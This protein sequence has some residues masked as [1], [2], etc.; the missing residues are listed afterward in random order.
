MRISKPSRN[1]KERRSV[2]SRAPGNQQKNSNPRLT[3][4]PLL[5]SRQRRQARPAAPSATVAGQGGVRA[6]RR[7]AISL[8]S[9]RLRRSEARLPHRLRNR[10]LPSRFPSRS[11]QWP[12]QAQQ[13]RFLQLLR[14]QFRPQPEV[15]TRLRLKGLR[16]VHLGGA[17][18]RRGQP[19]PERQREPPKQLHPA[20]PMPLPPLLMLVLVLG[21]LTQPDASRM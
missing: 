8:Q 14:A 7:R 21:R 19:E 5:T 9:H 17:A 10:P 6:V 1:R 18:V 16:P 4:T 2:R 11:M 20:L 15:Q 3:R 13:P 12:R